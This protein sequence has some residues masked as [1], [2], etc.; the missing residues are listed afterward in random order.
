MFAR[1]IDRLAGSLIREILQVAG[2][3]HMISFAAGLPTAGL[4]PTPDFSGFPVDLRQYGTTEGEPAL[5]QQIARHLNALGLECE[6]DQI[7]VTSGSQQGIDLVAKLFV[8]EGTPI[9]VEAPTFLAASQAFR[10]FGADFRE[11][12]LS[13]EGIAPDDL[14]CAIAAHRPA[15]AYLIPSFQNPTGYCYG[16]ARR[17]EI[18]RVLDESG[19]PLVE[20]EPYRDLVYEP[21]ARTPVSASLKRAPWVYLGSFSKTLCPGLRIGYLACSRALFP[22]FARLKQATDLHTNRPAQWWIADYL[23]GPEYGPHLERLRDHYRIRR[24]AMHA[25]LGRHFG[26]LADWTKPAGGLFFWVRLK[27]GCDTRLLLPRALERKVAFMPGEP[28]YANPLERSGCL[29]LNFSHAAPDQME[30]GIAVL[31]EVVEK[32]GAI[33]CAPERVARG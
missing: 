21:S 24:D 3:P 6:A 27:Q 15:F 14:T 16:E 12:P 23:S 30:R 19:T 29:R 32:Q 10:L 2:D 20:D 5:R 26:E 28:F 17:K 25:S 33:P 18:A 8:E 1:R 7:L 22:Y 31:A 13:P 11:L 4:M 9:L